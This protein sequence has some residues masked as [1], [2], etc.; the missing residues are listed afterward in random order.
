MIPIEI[1]PASG[2]IG[3][4]A[5]S[6]KQTES[7]HIGDS[8]MCNEWVSAKTVTDEANSSMSHTLTIG[9]GE[10]S[11]RNHKTTQEMHICQKAESVQHFSTVESS[12]CE[13]AAFH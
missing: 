6:G 12:E 11:H 7:E 9:S 1:Q 3:G 8:A 10:I 2:A 4:R 5:A 13:S